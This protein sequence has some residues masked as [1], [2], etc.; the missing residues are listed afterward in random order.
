MGAFSIWHALILIAIVPL[1]KLI[2]LWSF[3]F[4]PWPK[5]PEKT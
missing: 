4:S 3:A 2:V 1:F 5:F